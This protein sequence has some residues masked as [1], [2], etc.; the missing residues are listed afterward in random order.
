MQ[1]QEHVASDRQGRSWEG[2]QIPNDIHCQ[3]PDV[4]LEFEWGRSN[5]LV[6]HAESEYLKSEGRAGSLIEY[7][8]IKTSCKNLPV[9]LLYLT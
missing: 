4:D 6:L 8:T 5:E 9:Y 3:D 1:K 2:D 7:F